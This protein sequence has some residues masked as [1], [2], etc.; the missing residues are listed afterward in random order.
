MIVHTVERKT[1]ICVSEAEELKN[2]STRI[3]SSNFLKPFY[4]VMLLQ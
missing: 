1:L 3:S 2:A 4:L